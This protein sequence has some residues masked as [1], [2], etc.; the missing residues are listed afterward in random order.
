MTI[1]ANVE[2]LQQRIKRTLTPAERFHAESLLEDAQVEVEALYPL[3]DEPTEQDLAV[4]KVVVCRM[5]KR[6]V[7]VSD[8]MVGVSGWQQGAG[9]YQQSYNFAN[10]TGDMYLSKTDR[11]LLTGIRG[12]VGSI[13]LIAHL[14]QDA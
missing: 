12:R 14:T 7:Q 4:R 3:P 2:D 9:P 5:V 10:P 6:A 13:D 1:F 11:R 8:D